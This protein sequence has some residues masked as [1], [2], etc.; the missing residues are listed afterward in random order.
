MLFYLNVVSFG[1]DVP[2]I[3]SLICIEG[4]DNGRRF[5]VISA[6]FYVLLV[7]ILPIYQKAG[8]LVFL[9]FAISTPV[10]LT[11][12]LRRI[13]DSG[14]M[15]LLAIMPV[16]V[17]WLNVFGLIYIDHSA[18]WILL[19][20]GAITTLIISTISNIRVRHN[21]Q[22]LYG[23]H[24][25]INS[26]EQNNNDDVSRVE[27]T[28]AT[29]IFENLNPSDLEV[30]FETEL[31]KSLTN[32]NPKFFFQNQGDHKTHQTSQNKITAYHSFREQFTHWFSLN[33]SLAL[34]GLTA[35]LLVILII[36]FLLNSNGKHDVVVPLQDSQQT[37][38]SVFKKDRL[39]KLEMPDNFWLMLDQ[40]NA[41]TIGWQ[42]DLKKDGNYWSAITGKG[43]KTCTDL[44]FN[45]GE[46]IRSLE[47]TIKASEDYYADFS[48]VDTKQIILS[49]ANK[50]RFKLCG[51]EFELKG[52][53]SLLRQYKFYRDFLSQ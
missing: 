15:T 18:K 22:Y 37:S 29:N 38:V 52:T 32:S 9:L 30:N 34:A 1:A 26:T 46:K 8:I 12:S 45:L 51:Y 43:D 50:D 40:N 33:R 28:L 3:K 11:S 5:L 4:H 49:I 13:H 6:A 2:F 35:S 21:H 7:A 10:L 20:I 31:D 14:F 19:L 17:F 36:L 42:G 16:I 53:R 47:V 25:P 41:L 44:D 24:G 23:Y 39:H 27:P 48:P